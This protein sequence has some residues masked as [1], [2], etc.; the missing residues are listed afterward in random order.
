VEDARWIVAEYNKKAI[1]V[2]LKI[3]EPNASSFIL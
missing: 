3:N 2:S 1:E